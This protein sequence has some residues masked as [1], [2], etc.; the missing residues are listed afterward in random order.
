MKPITAVVFGVGVMGQDMTR[1]LLERG[2]SIVGAVARSPEKVGRDLGR[3]AGVGRDLGVLISSDADKLLA[4]LGADVAVIAVDSY[5]DSHAEHI[6]TCVRHGL[7][8]VTIAEEAFHPWGTAPE[9]AARLDALARQHGVTI[10][11]GGHQDIFWAGIG[12]LLMGASH[13]VD[14]VRW[15]TDFNPEG[16][17]RELLLEMGIG[18]DPS[19]L[20]VDDGQARP[21]SFGIAAV[22]A[23]AAHLGLPRGTVSVHSEPVIGTE[24]IYS[25]ALRREV[26]P[27]Q[28]VGVR[29]TVRRD[30]GPGE[31][32]LEFT[33]IGSISALEPGDSWQVIGKPGFKLSSR[34]TP[35]HDQV[36]GQAVNRIPDVLA[37]APGWAA[38]DSLPPLRY[39]RTF[40]RP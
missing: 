27:G 16:L 14:E 18:C 11:G 9:T 8:V 26:P 13:R 31:P 34:Y 33:M 7:N 37:A 17:S 35:G 24:P 22:D 3:V 10:Y 6:A 19:E 30:E 1:L 25:A 29:D 4:G 5:L 20:P 23:V 15:R 36:T 38:F 28:I 21:P 39:R 12:G 2:V 32:L 40:S